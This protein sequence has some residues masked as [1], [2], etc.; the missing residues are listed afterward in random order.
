MPLYSL[1]VSFPVSTVAA[2]PDLHARTGVPPEAAQPA[3]QSPVPFVH[4][5]APAC[6][7]DEAASAAAETAGL[8][9]ALLDTVQRRLVLRGASRLDNAIAFYGPLI[10]RLRAHLDRRCR[11]VFSVDIAL[12]AIDSGST[13][14]LFALFDTLNEGALAGTTIAVRWR[15]HGSDPQCFTFRNTLSERFPLLRFAD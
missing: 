4:G 2:Q 8:P 3:A 1:L 7:Q 15:G 10:G 11:E 6:L 5:Q 9:H 14:M 13:K 12:S